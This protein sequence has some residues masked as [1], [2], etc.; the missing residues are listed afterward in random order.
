VCVQVVVICGRN[1][2]LKAR[3]KGGKYGESM[4][5][6]AAGFV[7]NMH[8]F[9]G[10]CDAIITK[11]GALARSAQDCMAAGL[12][13]LLLLLLLGLLHHHLSSA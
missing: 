7:T 9:M 12:L 2:K 1:E 11:A 3:L 5:V 6:K 8:E 4:Q 13:L 10:A